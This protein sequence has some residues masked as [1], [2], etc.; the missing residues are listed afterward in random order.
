[1]TFRPINNLVVGGAGYIGSHFVRQLQVA[2]QTPFVLDNF[3]YGHRAAVADDIAFLMKI[4]AI[5]AR[6]EKLL[7]GICFLS[8]V[9]GEA[10]IG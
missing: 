10:F 6:L 2:G 3:V 9:F 5:A 1:M 4:W 8:E 7:L